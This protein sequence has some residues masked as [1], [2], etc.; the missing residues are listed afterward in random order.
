MQIRP[1][2]HRVIKEKVMADGSIQYSLQYNPNL[3]KLAQCRGVDTE[4]F[5]PV[6]EKFNLDEERYI[7]QRLCGNCPVKEACLEWALV[8]ER[9]GIWGGTTPW[10]RGHIRKARRWTF[11]EISLPSTQRR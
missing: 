8:H 4:V 5:Y 11:N 10:R 6:Q 3:F 9:Y 2:F 1:K 7:T